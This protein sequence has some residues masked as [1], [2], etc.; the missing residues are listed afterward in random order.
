V[1]SSPELVQLLGYALAGCT[2]SQIERLLLHF[3][4]ALQTSY[5]ALVAD[6][7]KHQQFETDVV[8]AVSAAVQLPRSAVSMLSLAAG[9]VVAEVQVMVPAAQA[10]NELLAAI[11]ATITGNPD[12]LFSDRFRSAYRCATHG[13]SGVAARLHELVLP[14]LRQDVSG[15]PRPSPPPFP[16]PCVQHHIAGDSRG[17]PGAATRHQRR[18][19]RQEAHGSADGGH[20]SRRAVCCAGHRRRRDCCAAEQPQQCVHARQAA[21]VGQRR[22]AC[23]RGCIRLAGATLG[24][25]R[26]GQPGS[27]LASPSSRRRPRSGQRGPLPWPEPEAPSTPEPRPLQS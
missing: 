24:R 3:S 11:A 21:S 19:G 8:N 1:S 18:C 26:P 14:L 13:V 25:A 4:L 15:M 27:H 7:A 23:T 17:T 5:E 20:C 6:G 9:S 10:T 22:C 12:A 16:C 2:P